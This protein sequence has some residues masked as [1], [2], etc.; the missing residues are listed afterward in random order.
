M[1]GVVYA[2][3]GMSEGGMYLGAMRG[4]AVRGGGG[5]YALVGDWIYYWVG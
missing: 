1:R 4:D 5:W 2:W 3:S